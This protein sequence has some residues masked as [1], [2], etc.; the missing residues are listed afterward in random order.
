MGM[1]ETIANDDKDFHGC[2]DP[3]DILSL[4]SRPFCNQ[5]NISQENTNY[6]SKVIP[7]C[8]WRYFAETTTGNVYFLNPNNPFNIDYFGFLRKLH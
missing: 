5:R 8:H 4:T 3:G 6:D 7:N 1:M 2:I